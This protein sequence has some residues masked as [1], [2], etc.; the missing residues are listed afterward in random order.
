MKRLFLM[1]GL[2]GGASACLSMG[3]VQTA[4][5]LGK[6]N[7]QVSAEPGIYGATG[8]A[9]VKTP[10]PDGGMAPLG[11][12]DPIPHFDVSFRY[13]VTDRFDLGVRTGW[14]LIELQTKFL[15]SPPEHQW[16]AVSVAPTLGAAFIGGGSASAPQAT[17]TSFNLAVPLLF[18]F[19]H[20]RGNEFIVGLRFNNLVFAFGDASGSLTVYELGIGATIGY[21]FQVGEIF[22][23]L[24]EFAFHV[25]A[26]VTGG[27]P[28]KFVAASAGT[29]G[30]IAQLKIGLLFGR[31]KFV[32]E[33]LPPPP[34]MSAPEPLT[35]P[36][37]DDGLTPP[38]AV[39]PAPPPEE[40]IPPP[41]PPP[42]PTLTPI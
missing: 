41:P 8:S 11:V 13:G 31:S 36:P 16:L 5:T 15:L 32:P 42:A 30:V 38:D 22:K 10:T 17:I 6:G 33:P 29:H 39:Q 28:G 21:A 35:R 23:I 12:Q 4:S 2:L 20:F 1:A 3:T 9:E 24:P 34:P 19:K 7:F 14:S 27:I 40:K 25:P 18:G 26:A 37:P